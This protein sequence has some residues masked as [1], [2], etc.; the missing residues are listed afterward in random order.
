MN[1]EELNCLSA[2]NRLEH[3]HLFW[4]AKEALFKSYGQKQLDWKTEYC[5]APFE[6]A[7]LSTST[8]RIITTTETLYFDVYMRIMNKYAMAYT[9]LK[10]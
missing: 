3:L 8:G 6:F 9:V 10:K 2:N 5:I 7:P 4:C 1:E